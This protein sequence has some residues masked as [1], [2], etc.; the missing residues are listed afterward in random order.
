MIVWMVAGKVLG[1]GS[2]THNQP[3]EGPLEL[4]SM[5]LCLICS[6][7]LEPFDAMVALPGF[8]DL[9]HKEQQGEHG[10]MSIS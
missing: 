1:L 10:C 9:G 3:T 2:P 5:H 6:S 4:L 8:Q 7:S